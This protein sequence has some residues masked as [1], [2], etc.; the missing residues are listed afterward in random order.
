MAVHREQ[1]GA[2]VNIP[3]L[4]RPAIGFA[5]GLFAMIL[6]S[7]CAVT[8]P[9][10][11]GVG[12]WPGYYEPYGADYGGWGPGFLVGPVG[13]GG[14]R[15]ARGG[16]GG[17]QHAF[18]ASASRSAPSIPGGRGGGARGGGGRGGGGHGGGHR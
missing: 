10:Y 13:G 15:G 14:Y 3:E 4:R 11:G 7:G 12:V 9:G 17:G 1:K 2:P 16:F 8:D 6:T 18:R 5:I